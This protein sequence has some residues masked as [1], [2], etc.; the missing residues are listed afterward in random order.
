MKKISLILQSL[1]LILLFGA[2]SDDDGA[3]PDGIYLYV[4]EATVDAGAGEKSVTVA[5]TCDWTATSDSE[6]LT[7][8]P[9]SGTTGIVA[10]HAVY[11]ANTGAEPRTGVI[12]FKAGTY[13]E[14]LTINQK[15]P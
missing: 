5:A 4:T 14:T 11:T 13:V 3:K 6:W 7:V 15:K 1:L 2:C 10:V 8:A 12:T 9:A